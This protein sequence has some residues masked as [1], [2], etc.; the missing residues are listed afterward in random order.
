M[1]QEMKKLIEN[2]KF[3]FFG[4]K[5]GVGKTTMAASTAVWLADQGYD[6]LIVAT[7]PTVSLSVTY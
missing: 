7:D 6:T 3:L 2:R 4:G 1:T 5:G